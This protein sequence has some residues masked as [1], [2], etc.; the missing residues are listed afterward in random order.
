MF[1]CS[2]PLVQTLIHNLIVAA[3]SSFV[4]SPS[5][6]PY[7]RHLLY[8][9]FVSVLLDPSSLAHLCLVSWSHPR[10]I[11][12]FARY[13]LP[14]TI[15]PYNGGCRG[16]YPRLSYNSLYFRVSFYRCFRF[17]QFSCLCPVFRLFSFSFRFFVLF[18]LLT[19]ITFLTAA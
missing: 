5:P 8:L 7:P 4:P 3:S 15:T 2:P 18:L 17:C 16:C 19:L 1:A 14:T 12:L 6:S 10:P 9:I 13:P 11:I